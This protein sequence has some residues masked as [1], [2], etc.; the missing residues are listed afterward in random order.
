MHTFIVHWVV[1]IVVLWTGAFVSLQSAIAQSLSDQA[2]E[3]LRTRIEVAGVPPKI[4]VGEELI[5]ASMTLLLFYERRMYRPAWTGDD[6]PLPQ[7]YALLKAISEAGREGLKPADYHLVKIECTLKKVRQNPGGKN[8]LD[9]RRLVDLDLLLTDAFLI[10]GSHLLAGRI[11]P[12]TIDPEWHANL[13]EADLASVLQTALDSNQIEEALKNLLPPQ[14][15]YNR[16]KQALARYRDIAAKGGWSTVPPGPKMKK[17]DTG[18]RVVV[19][20]NRL[21]ATCD[22]DQKP[23][24]NKN[25]FD[26]DLEEEVRRFQRRHG[27]DADGI[28][29]PLTLAELNVPVEQ[30]VRQIELNLERWRWLP[31]DLGKRFILV[32][33]AN[34]EL[35]VVEDG[36][37]VMTMRAVVGRHY[38]R[39]PVFSGKMTYLVLSPYWH[40]P[41]G[42]AVKDKLPLIRK[43]PD[44]LVEQNIKVFQGWGA[45]TKE[46]DPKTVDWSKVTAKNFNY[47]LRQEPGPLNALGGVKF[48]FPNKFDVY[49]HDTP[50]RELFAKT[51]RT[52]S[53]GCIRIEKAIELAEYVL[54]GDP[55]WTRETILAAIGKRV[56]QNVRLPEPIPVHLLYWTAWTDEDG[57]I[58]FRNDIYGRDK[59]LDEALRE[60]PPISM[61]TEQE[62]LKLHT[63]DRWRWLL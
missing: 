3:L 12:E 32:N 14:L 15:G 57:S 1:G 17:G 60:K 28:V 49:L 45:E 6:G 43:N 55:K 25:I 35:D 7:V 21:I 10:Y 11:N 23:Y 18:E 24:N 44:Y 19:L 8:L 58:E 48:M 52:F 53:S 5:H 50:S 33:I 56:E 37:L 27:L 22:L 59:T 46:I 13:R 4:T 40:T 16:L 34:F 63:L 2:S 41:P 62:V 38:R 20:C 51:V 42:I 26:D 54:R 29:G 30:R 9:P 47:R 31:Q 39:T 61:K 36:Q